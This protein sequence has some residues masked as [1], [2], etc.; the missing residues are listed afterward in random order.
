MNQL[1]QLMLEE[2]H[3]RN[4]ADTTIRCYLH[5]ESAV[6]PM[7]LSEQVD[8]FRVLRPQFN[9]K[10]QGR[11]RRIVL[12]GKCQIVVVCVGIFWFKGNARD[13]PAK[14]EMLLERVGASRC[15]VLK[16]F[17][18]QSACHEFLERPC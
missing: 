9:W 1:R 2:L 5:G 11:S 3:R 10:P 7:G 16:L 17:R 8:L 13:R 18:R 15:P 12:E 6:H 4:F 14:G